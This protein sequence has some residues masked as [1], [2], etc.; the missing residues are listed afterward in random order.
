M[1]YRRTKL[2]Y[3]LLLP[4]L[5]LIGTL[6]LYPTLETVYNSFFL[7]RTQTAAQGI[8]F[9][10]LGNY[11]KLLKDHVFWD[12]LGWTILF[13]LLSVGLELVIGT[14]LAVLMT[15][16][17]PGQKLIRSTILIPWAMPM[18]VA[19][20]IWAQVFSLDGFLNSVLKTA[21]FLEKSVPWLGTEATAKLAVLIAD[22]WK[23]TPYMSLL[24][25]AGMITID[26]Q[27]YEAAKLDGAGSWMQFWHITVPL[28]KPTMMVTL[29][30][31][32]ISAMRV[33]DLIVAMTNGGPGGS[34]TT[35]SMYAMN[36]YFT[37]GNIGY[38][39]AMSVALLIISVIISLFFVDSL[40]SRL[41]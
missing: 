26:K 30:F 2:G 5:L 33:Y 32:I 40:Q 18:I 25:M 11:A 8:S 9:I 31:R 15:Q 1:H 19:G 7:Y 10:G 17:I 12:A 20:I 23:N 41:N 4:A 28:V 27:Y 24:L 34:T 39:S 21:G 29:L 37:Y 38:G 35:V 6:I 36:T 16:K 13:T 14:F 22:V 3:L